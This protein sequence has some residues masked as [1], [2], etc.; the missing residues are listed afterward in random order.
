MVPKFVSV[1]EV[2]SDVERGGGGGGRGIQN[3][4]RL[5]SQYVKP[6]T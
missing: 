6:T 2:G 3:K 5:I 1:Y 4:E